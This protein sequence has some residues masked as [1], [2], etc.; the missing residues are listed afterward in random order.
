MGR[1]VG[2]EVSGQVGRGRGSGLVGK[3]RGEWA[4]R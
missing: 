4:G 1:K 3:G 2:V